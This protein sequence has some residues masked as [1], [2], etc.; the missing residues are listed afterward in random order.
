MPETGG[1]DIATL[2]L[3]VDGRQ[4]VDATQALDRFRE[5][6]EKAEAQAKSFG[7]T[8]EDVARLN[9]KT[10]QDIAQAE[11]QWQAEKAASEK[12]A[13]AQSVVTAKESA[14]AQV[15]AIER[16]YKLS[17]AA[18][19][20]AVARG[21]IGPKEA[22]KAGR[23][24][25]K[26]YN[27]SLVSIIDQTS[28]A[29]G[30]SRNTKA[31]A[32]A[33]LDLTGSLKNVDAA[34]RRANLG[35]GRLN[36]AMVTVARQGLGLNTVSGK[37]IDTV[38]TFAIGTAYMVPVLAGL[39]AIGYAWQKLTEE[40]RKAREEA[41]KAIDTLNE[42]A[43]LRELGPAGD[44]S[45]ELAATLR[46]QARLQRELAIA[47]SA[48]TDSNSITGA[49]L[50]T[51]RSQQRHRDPE[52]IRADLE[53]VAVAVEEGQRQIFEN[54][55]SE[56]ER[57]D[58]E[59]ER[60]NKT[61][62]KSADEAIRIEEQKA[63]G[64]ERLAAE[65]ARRR[66][67][68]GGVVADLDQQ[69]SDARRLAAA[70][71]IGAD[72]V[73]EVN[74]E[75]S[76]EQ[77]L[78][79]ALANAVPA[80]V[81][82][83]TSRVNAL[84]DLRDAEAETAKIRET[85]QQEVAESLKTL[86][87]TQARLREEEERRAAA[88]QAAAQ[89]WRDAWVNA[90]YDVASA[91]GDAARN[92][93]AFLANAHDAIREASRAGSNAEKRSIGLGVVGGFAAAAV[94]SVIDS[95]RERAE[96]VRQATE[97]FD[98]VLDEYVA[99]LADRSRFEQLAADAESGARGALDALLNKL[100]ADLATRGSF[101]AEAARKIKD[102]IAQGLDQQGLESILSQFGSEGQQILSIY[103]DLLRQIDEERQKEIDAATDSLRVRELAAQ[104]L[105]DEADALRRQIQYEQELKD[106]FELGGQALEDYTRSVQ[107]QEEAARAAAEA[108]RDRAEAVRQLNAQ[109]SHA[110]DLLSA[111][112]Q[113]RDAFIA[114]LNIKRNNSI[115][116]FT[117]QFNDGLISQAALTK[118]IA[119][120][121]EI[122]N[123][124][125][126][127]YDQAL[128]DSAAAALE[129]A[130]AE[131]FRQAVDLENLKIRGLIAQ[132]LDD[133]AYL[134][135]QQ[136]ELLQAVEQ[137]RSAEYI[138]LLKQVQ[139]QELANRE[140]AKA[141]DAAKEAAKAQDELTRALDG[142]LKV[143][144]GPA[145]F[146][147]QV[148]SYRNQALRYG[149]GPGD[150]GVSSPQF[151][152]TTNNSFEIVIQTQPGQDNVTIGQIVYEQIVAEVE[153]N[154]RLGGFNRLS[155]F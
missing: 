142:G 17:E 23:E 15:D 33:F 56:Q 54:L 128:L 40:S 81:A 36:D 155:G 60:A 30:L 137:G 48:Q 109:L 28:A 136:L 148:Q 76:R 107:E 2:G 80:D 8:T 68:S 62:S 31:G 71:R 63:R 135:K 132:G 82:A 41:E 11:A 154:K 96:A 79:Q 29:G 51:A 151:T 125:L 124:A 95:R 117:Q 72:A 37:L 64:L 16:E 94:S 13:A 52:E 116:E 112:G 49:A 6:G 108:E 24:A 34:G 32:D 119:E 44:A 130:R 102:A 144:G 152:P 26:A 145:G 149:G 38:G 120:S 14:R 83:I 21:F 57:I 111:R 55:S 78:R 22:A 127:E 113:D 115:A 77:A 110:Q 70:N 27:R 53:R 74:R 122:F 42:A 146:T 139:A 92:S 18:I 50:G 39:A 147:A 134:M 65:T 4:L 88:A 133:E 58:A 12:R 85:T 66:A 105:D 89:A 86:E 59:R 10:Y 25:A 45:T 100:L 98:Q 19:K 47:E 126:A 5:T 153:R 91:F 140:A 118:L 61:A 46:E 114:G 101:G 20:E 84:Y 1:L 97:E 131:E 106:A 43:R 121:N 3:R 103:L 143:L 129:A 99:T 93:A 90:A 35:L 75:L 138:A 104:G 73:E 7:L 123:A 69:L 87:E 141:A 67:A 9:K 150:L